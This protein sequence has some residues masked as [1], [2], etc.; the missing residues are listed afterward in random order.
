MSSIEC[1]V[2]Y[3]EQDV[4]RHRQNINLKNYD[5]LAIFT[6]FKEKI[7]KKAINM[8]CDKVDLCLN[9]EENIVFMISYLSFNYL[10][11]VYQIDQKNHLL[12]LES[13]S[14]KK[15]RIL[16]RYNEALYYLPPM[17]LPLALWYMY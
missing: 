10:I 17:A 2:K 3:S 12:F 7:I 5:N 11:E 13:Y 4:I 16:N 9:N 1:H 15:S 6:I 14:I 8:N